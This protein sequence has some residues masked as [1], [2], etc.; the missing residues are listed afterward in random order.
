M[1]LF[2]Y[3][4]YSNCL[5]PISSPGVIYVFLYG[6]LSS[7]PLHISS[8]TYILI[9]LCQIGVYVLPLSQMISPAI[10]P[11]CY[12]IHRLKLIVIISE[13]LVQRNVHNICH[14]VSVAFDSTVNLSGVS[15]S[16]GRALTFHPHCFCR[17]P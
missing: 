12:S 11:L 17:K 1:F 9:S 5:F 15:V 8:Y 16:H 6:S 2:L 4:F 7:Q 13:K 10:C 3:D 14:C